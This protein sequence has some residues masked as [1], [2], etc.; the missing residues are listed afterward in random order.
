MAF[1]LTDDVRPVTDLKSHPR[2]LLEKLRQSGR[3]ILIT[4]RGRGAAILEGMEAYRKRESYY[5]TIEA[6]L[7]GLREAE[8]GDLK[9]HEEALKI[10]KDF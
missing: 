9:N 7:Q 6:I 2:E 5:A 3:P 8:E 4:Q 1:Q 10:L